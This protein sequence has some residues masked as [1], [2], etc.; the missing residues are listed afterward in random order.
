MTTRI[1]LKT[2]NSGNSI[3]KSRAIFSKVCTL[4]GIGANFVCL[5]CL[6][7]LLFDS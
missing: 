3:P 1:G 5:L 2:S 4:L 7:A 6:S